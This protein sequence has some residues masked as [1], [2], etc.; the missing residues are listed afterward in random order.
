M[1]QIDGVGHAAYRQILDMRALAAENGDN[2]VGI[3]LALQR[4]QVVGH[5]DKVHLRAQLHLLVTP[6]TV[7]KDAELAARHQRADLLLH[8][9]QFI[10]TVEGRVDTP[11]SMSAAFCG[12][13]S[14][15]AVMSTQSSAE[16]W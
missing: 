7:G 13:A 1:H 4:L 12:L 8:L 6:V 15:A 3:A 2:A 5:G 11:L 10:G 16:S 9:G 14:R